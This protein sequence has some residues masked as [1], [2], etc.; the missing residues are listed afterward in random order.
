MIGVGN[1]KGETFMLTG[2]QPFCPVFRVDQHQNHTTAASYRNR[3]GA[4]PKKL[5]RQYSSHHT[6][7]VIG[8]GLAYMRS[9]FIV[10]YNQ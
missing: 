9:G 1:S 3:S 6:N 4:M 2:T 7:G 10:S 8:L 5:K